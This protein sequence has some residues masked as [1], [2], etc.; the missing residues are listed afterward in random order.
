MWFV[1][2]LRVAFP[3]RKGYAVATRVPLIGGVVEKML[4]EGD[5]LIALPIEKVISVGE[6]I[7]DPGA[8]VAPSEV[9]RHFVNKAGF[10]WIMDNCICRQS[11]RCADYPVDLGC[12]FLGEAAKD[13]NPRLGRPATREEALDHLRRCRE[14]GLFHLVGRNKL[15]TF[16]L[17]VG[18]GDRLL[19]IC[20]C[21]TCC[22]LWS[23]LPDV[24]ERIGS[25][26][27][28]MPGVSV[29]V[30]DRCT[31]CGTC[32]DTA[33]CLARAIEVRD[34]RAYISED[35]RGCGH[36]AEVC[37]QGALEVVVDDSEFIKRAIERIESK[38]DVR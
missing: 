5:D 20:N 28:R 1:R 35:C 19:T 25:K 27:T 22:C 36:C 10:I 32:A 13:I 29:I 15:D 37:P 21:C 30:T 18:P 14:A 16:W 31:G 4:F 8:V 23:I 24:A 7:R 11:T 12:V 6:D 34:G 38:V 9:V 2:M 33:R 17:K 3:Y 26:Y